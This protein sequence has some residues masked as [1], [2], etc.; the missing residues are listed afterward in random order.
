MKKTTLIIASAV[1]FAG[2]ITAIPAR[3]YACYCEARSSSAWGWGRHAS[4]ARS[5]QIALNQC[6]LRTPRGRY[7]YVTFCS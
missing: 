6:A 5:Q 1:L 2:V 4:C 3:A 7:C